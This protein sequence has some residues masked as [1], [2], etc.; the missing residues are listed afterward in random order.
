MNTKKYTYTLYIIVMVICVTIGIQWYWNY[1]N[2]LFNKQQLIKDVQ[3]SL[4]KAVDDYY[5]DLA[6]KTTLGFEIEGEAQKDVL[7]KGNF[8]LDI[9]KSI[10]STHAK[11][12]TLDSL[13]INTD[14]LKGVK[15]YRGLK[16]DSLY[17]AQGIGSNENNTVF[18]KNDRGKN[19]NT[20]DTLDMSQIGLLTSKIVISIKS[21]S[22]NV[23]HID[24]L[25]KADLQRKSIPISYHLK[26][27]EGHDVFIHKNEFANDSTQTKKVLHVASNSTFLPKDSSLKIYFENINWAVFKRI[28]SGILISVLLVLAVISCLFYLLRIIKNQKQLAEIK[29]DLISNMTHEFKTPIATIGVALESIKNFRAIEDKEK[30]KKYLTM[31]EDQLGKLNLMVEKLLET[32]TLDSNNLELNKEETDIRTLVE[33]LVEKHRLQTEKSIRLSLPD[34]E[35]IAQVDAFHLENAINNILDNAVK[36]GGETIN[37]VLSQRASDFSLSISDSGDSLKKQHKDKIFE[38]FYRAPKGNTHDVK[39]F[40]IGLYYTKK[41]VEKHQGNIALELQKQLTTFKITIPNG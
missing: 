27:S 15:F 14:S 35:L 13:K 3:I 6:Q 38:K 1:K 5:T 10:D 21:D 9:A 40:G 41:I 17:K 2:Y 12:K 33:H 36:Y 8:L 25:L 34:K 22:V 32:A 39:G 4:D 26:F 37:V 24:S 18:L 29:N 23:K 19:W 28:L 16:A 31:S 11:Y 30:T 20:N 7:G